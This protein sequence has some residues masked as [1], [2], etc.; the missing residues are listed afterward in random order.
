MT[1]K[2]NNKVI[3]FLGS[4]A[5]RPFSVLVT[6]RLPSYSVF[7]DSTQCLPLN[8]YT[9]EG[10]RV[11]NITEWGLR[12]FREHYDGQGIGIT[13]ER[14]FAYTYAVL[15]DPV[16]REK[17]AVDLLREFPRLPLYDDFDLW[18]DMGQELLD[19]H[20]GFERL[21]PYGLERRD[22]SRDAGKARLRADKEL[23]VI[24]LDEQTTLVRCAVRSLG[25]STRQSIRA[26]VGA[27]SI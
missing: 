11:C 27:R 24:S 16:Y 9:A 1:R 10:E 8:R 25:I 18:A 20:I 15:H 13:A 19:L 4:G 26:R 17:Y 23:G 6:D 21:E 2:G 12:Q 22:V 3:C 5:R 14:I 7:I